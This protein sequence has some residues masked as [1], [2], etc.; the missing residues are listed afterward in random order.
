VTN[1][2]A[3]QRAGSQLSEMQGFY[4]LAG[5][6]DGGRAAVEELS[7]KKADK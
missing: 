7:G 1:A 5:C 6:H 3:R 2:G 4:R